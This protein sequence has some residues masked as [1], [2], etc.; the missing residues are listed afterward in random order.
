[1]VKERS[2]N[3]A[4]A[5]RKA[6]KAKAIKKGKAE[7]ALR[8]NEKLARRNPDRLQRQLDDLKALDDSGTALTSHEKK[9]R[10]SLEKEIRAVRQ[11]RE[12]FGDV[13][14]KLGR[15]TQ[16]SEVD[17]KK[18]IQL[19]KNSEIP[20]KRKREDE[21]SDDTDV[22]EDVK[23]I[24]M[25][26]DTP[27]PIPKAA[28]DKWYDKQRARKLGAPNQ[29]RKASNANLLPVSDKRRMLGRAGH[30]SD[31]SSIPTPQIAAQIVYESKPIVRDLLK[32][33]VAFVPTAVKAKLD[34][35]KGIRTLVEPEEA[36][37][38]EREG[39]RTKAEVLRE[40]STHNI[41]GDVI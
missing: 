35:S 6:E 31:S 19:H 18:Y 28:L 30:I 7:A 17:K 8:R 38:L 15:G 34:R 14:S 41:L 27:P 21:S 37:Q 1:M 9:L 20:G 12:N 39:Y 3:P 23:D 4:Q 2:I 26:R 24:P 40:T 5:Q 11:A 33:A 29:A 16:Q 32:E 25:P 22:P 36:D 10:E 13:T